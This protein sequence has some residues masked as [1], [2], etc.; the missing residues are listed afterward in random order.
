[1]LPLTALYLVFKKNALTATHVSG[2][3]TLKQHVL[4]M[5]IA[6]L[7]G[8]YDGFYGPGTGTFLLLCLTGIAKLPINLAAGTTKVINLT[9]NLTGLAVFLF[10]GKTVLVLGITAGI[11]GILG[12]YLGARHFSRSGAKIAKPIILA[13][14]GL[15]FIKLII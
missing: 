1:V 13:V 9:T 11:F 14:L 6:V 5:L 10:N 2:N 3:L 8:V 15:F 12:N 7:L 4:I